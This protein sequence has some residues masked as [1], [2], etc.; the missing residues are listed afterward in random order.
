MMRKMAL[1]LILA[2]ALTGCGA[3]AGTGAKVA[4]AG[5]GKGGAGAAPSASL[6]Q[7]EMGVK[8]AQCMRE[9]GVQVEDPK[10]GKGVMLKFDKGSGVSEATVNKAMEACRQYD[11]QA[12]ASPEKDAK[13]AEN[14]RKFA[15]CMRENGVESFADPAPGQRGIKIDGKIADD[16]DFQKAQEACQ[17]LLSAGAGQ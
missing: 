4:S 3:Q 10:P 5:D 7:D 9:N 17:A 13:M 1:P 6:S 14:G 8:F 15:A 16:P 11:P 2:L 12:N